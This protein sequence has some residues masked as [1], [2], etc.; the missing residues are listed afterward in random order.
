MKI[1][2]CSAFRGWTT[3]VKWFATN[4]EAVQWWVEHRAGYG[5]GATREIVEKTPAKETAAPN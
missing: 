1:T 4:D 2:W 3:E 5:R